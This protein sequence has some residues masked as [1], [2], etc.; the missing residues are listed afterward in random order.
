MARFFEFVL[1]SLIY[2]KRTTI[3]YP[4][5]EKIFKPSGTLQTIDWQNSKSDKNKKIYKNLQK[6]NSNKLEWN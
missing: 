6:Q 3:N 5:D 2:L 1:H 4:A